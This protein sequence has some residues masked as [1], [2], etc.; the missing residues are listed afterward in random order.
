MAYRRLRQ[1]LPDDLTGRVLRALMLPA[2]IEWPTVVVIAHPDDETLAM[3]GRLAMFERLTIVQLT[4]GA[5]RMAL[6]RTAWVAPS[7]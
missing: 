6:M 1:P 2:R 7:A 3:A 4:D 5:P